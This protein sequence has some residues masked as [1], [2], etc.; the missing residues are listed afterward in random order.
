MLRTNYILAIFVFF[1]FLPTNDSVAQTTTDVVKPAA[2]QWDELNPRAIGFVKDY[3]EVHE[4]RLMRMKE[5]GTPYFRLI[6]SILKRY[7]L[8]SSLKYLAVI[9]SDLKANAISSAGAVGPWQ[10]MPGTARDL[11]LTVSPTIDERTDLNKSTHAAAAYLTELYKKLG[12]WLL[13]VAAYNGGPAR[14][15]NVITKKK[16]RD[17]W[18]IQNELPAESRN[19]V[20]KF[21]ATHYIF[22]RNGSETTGLKIKKESSNISAEEM[23]MSDTM[24]LTGKYIDLVIAKYLAMDIALFTKWNPGFN[25]KVGL[26]N[27]TLRIPKDK[28]ELLRLRKS[29]IA[30][31]PLMVILQGGL[32]NDTGF[33]APVNMPEPVM[34]PIKKGRDQKSSSSSKPPPSS[35]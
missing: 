13:V 9:E 5:W 29:Q 25:E 26:E 14:V 3:L 1:S 18:N 19:H 23:A 30:Q 10:L 4:D 27:Y 34:K 20:K 33:P 8:P 6:E 24:V 15:D 11:G 35:K 16:S 17:F 28:M 21:I 7:Q 2:I 32:T 22:E 12:D 31:E